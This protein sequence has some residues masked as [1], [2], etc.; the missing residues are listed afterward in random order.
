MQYRQYILVLAASLL[1][2]WTYQRDSA[3]IGTLAYA[4]AKRCQWR[5]SSSST[6]T[7][8]TTQGQH[9]TLI[10]TKSPF[11][12]HTRQTPRLDQ[13]QPPLLTTPSWCFL[14]P[15]N[16]AIRHEIVGSPPICAIIVSD[17]DSH[18]SPSTHEPVSK[19]EGPISQ[20]LRLLTIRPVER[21][22]F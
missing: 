15:A 18:F 3:I 12:L 16:Q 19:S 11:S 1:I 20:S 21:P 14:F 13:A 7:P 2:P 6:M 22:I 10:S 17:P 4:P 5:T 9:P 8:H